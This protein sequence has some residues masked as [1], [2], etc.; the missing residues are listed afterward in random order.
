M[1]THWL[2]RRKANDIGKQTPQVIPFNFVMSSVSSTYTCLHKG[3]NW[4][5]HKFEPFCLPYYRTN[6][7]YESLLHNLFSS[8]LSGSIVS[9]LLSWIPFENLCPFLFLFMFWL[10]DSCYT[11]IETFTWWNLRLQGRDEFGNRQISVP[12]FEPLLVYSGTRTWRI[13]SWGLNDWE[14]LSLLLRT[15]TNK[16]R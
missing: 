6:P 9:P 16:I 3:G 13:N 5:L 10:P 11:T 2:V 12:V 8:E 14:F 7:L 4:T 15:H 1:R